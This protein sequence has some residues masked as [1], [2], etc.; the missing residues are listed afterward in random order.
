M[1]TSH[2]QQVLEKG[3]TSTVG[4]LLTPVFSSRDK[5]SLSSHGHTPHDHSQG[6][7]HQP[8]RQDGQG[9]M[10]GNQTIPVY[11]FYMGQGQRPLPDPVSSQAYG[12]DQKQVHVQGLP[13]Q[14]QVSG[15]SFMT[16]SQSQDQYPMSYGQNLPQGQQQTDQGVHQTAQGQSASSSVPM[17]PPGQ[18][19]QN[20]GQGQRFQQPKVMQTQQIP[21]QQQIPQSQMYQQ[22]T[23]IS[24]PYP[25]GGQSNVSNAQN[26]LYSAQQQFSSSNQQVPLQ[27]GTGQTSQWQV[28]GQYQN[29]MQNKGPIPSVPQGQIQ[30][31]IPSQAPSSQTYGH[32]QGQVQGQPQLSVQNQTHYQNQQARPPVPPYSQTEINRAL[33]QQIMSQDQQASQT[34]IPSQQTILQGQFQGNQQQQYSQGQQGQGHQMYGQHMVVSGYQQGMAAESTVCPTGLSRSSSF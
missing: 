23:G 13:V 10:M 22:Q 21:Q 4:T 1:V 6:V 16:P 15:Q 30:G 8:M 24:Q 31:E 11:S 17:Q 2:R 26:R 27:S 20:I 25:V 14:G 5:A 34:N 12:K 7:P 19:P 32:S 33:T 18:N 29:Q 9:Q 28:Q 3:K